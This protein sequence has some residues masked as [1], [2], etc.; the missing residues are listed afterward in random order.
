MCFN[1]HFRSDVYTTRHYEND[2][3]NTWSTMWP[4]LTQ[5]IELPKVQI[6]ARCIYSVHF[7]SVQACVLKFL[8]TISIIWHY[9]RET[10]ISLRGLHLWDWWVGFTDLIRVLLYWTSVCC[11]SALSASRIDEWNEM[12]AGTIGRRQWL[13]WSGH[14]WSCLID[15]RQS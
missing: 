13:E 15:V 1:D 8:N 11:S 10:C 6:H 12:S 3:W 2:R 5:A 4:I 7:V 14:Q 9:A